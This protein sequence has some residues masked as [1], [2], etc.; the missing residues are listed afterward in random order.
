MNTLGILGSTGSI[1]CQALQVAESLPEE[2]TV[3][4][5]AAGQNVELLATQAK[6][7][8]PKVVAIAAEEKYRELKHALTGTNI[9]V[10]A[11]EEGLSYVAAG[12][13]SSTV[14]AA[15]VGIAGLK[16]TLA[17]IQQGKRVALANKETLVTAG[18][19]V[20]QAKVKSGAEILPV[21]SEHS[22]IWQCLRSGRKE[23]V[24]N[25]ILTASGGP[26]RT[27]TKDQLAQVTVR[28][29]LTHPNWTMGAK[30]TIDSAT[31]MNKGL[32]ILEAKWLFELPLKK[33]KVLVHPESIVH[34]LVEFVDGSVV[35]QLS[36]PDM[37]LPIQLALTYPKRLE[38]A[39]PRLNLAGKT[40]TFEEPDTE[41]FPSLKL[42]C[43]AGEMDG[44]APAVLNAANEI[45]VEEFLRGRLPFNQIVPTV[46]KVLSEHKVQAD[47]D[48]DT[49]LAVD[50]WARDQAR[51]V[52]VKE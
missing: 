26:F 45:S 40:L 20:Q 42:A 41:R 11:G 4:A 51:K 32:E 14:L 3:T 16:P 36:L 8:R 29:A 6:K 7:F 9:R 19:I 35:G 39:W 46:E 27:W 49:I 21:D 34:S 48:L 22:A 47:P 10:L 15:I 12:T 52:M 28:D 25:L 33:I 23:E 2:I 44:T 50:A 13:E 17:A 5:L 18:R 1:G 38:A 31:L 30:I 24:K 43:Q 37:R